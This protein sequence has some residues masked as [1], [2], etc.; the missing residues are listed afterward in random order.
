MARP[1]NSSAVTANLVEAADGNVTVI[2]LPLARAFTLWADR[3]TARTVPA[4]A[5][6]AF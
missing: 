3:M 1:K 4:L 5:P 6:E 2:V